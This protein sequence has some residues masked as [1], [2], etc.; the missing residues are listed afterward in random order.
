MNNVVHWW[1]KNQETA[2]ENGKLL[3]SGKILCSL[4]KSRVDLF[5]FTIVDS[6][7]I[8]NSSGKIGL[9]NISSLQRL[10]YIIIISFFSNWKFKSNQNCVDR[11]LINRNSEWIYVNTWYRL[12]VSSSERNIKREKCL[13][14]YKIGLR[15]SSLGK[16]IKYH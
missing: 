1:K 3:P 12:I 16:L 5:T 15:V 14:P 6:V 7:G 9:H 4:G 11:L 13:S 8:L 10:L 2:I